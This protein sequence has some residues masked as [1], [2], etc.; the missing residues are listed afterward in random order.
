LRLG[1]FSPNYP[2]VTGDG[3]IGT[4]TRV[5]AESLA[6]NGHTVNVVTT[7]N[8]PQHLI[9]GNV[10][11]DVVVRRPVRIV[12]R[13]APETRTVWSVGRAALEAVTSRNLDLFEFPNWEGLG[14]WFGL[15]RRIP[16]VVRLSTSSAETQSI[17]ALPATWTRRCDRARERLL[18]SQADALV[19]HSYAHR[20]TMA[21]ELHIDASRIAVVPLGVPVFPDFVRPAI[22]RPNPTVVFLGRLERRKGALDLLKAIPLVLARVPRAHARSSF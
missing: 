10:P 20:Q 8:R 7:G 14:I 4:Y 9:A 6:Q 17:D 16:L 18:I 5:L 19:T 12:D 21:A 1:L 13:F 22:E 11:L 3:G 2:G 15:R